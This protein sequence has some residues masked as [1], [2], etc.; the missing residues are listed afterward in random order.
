MFWIRSQQLTISLLSVHYRFYLQ[1]CEQLYLLLQNS[2]FQSFTE[3]SRTRCSSVSM[4]AR[5]RD[6]QERNRY[7]ISSKNEMSILVF[8]SHRSS[9]S[10][11]TTFPF[12][13]IKRPTLKNGSVTPFIAKDKNAWSYNSSC[14]AVPNYDSTRTNLLL[15]LMCKIALSCDITFQRAYYCNEQC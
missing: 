12:P 15:P 9:Y 4:V 6:G 10:V 1:H 11:T 8:G 3:S 7:S 13:R 14:G 5:L 2:C